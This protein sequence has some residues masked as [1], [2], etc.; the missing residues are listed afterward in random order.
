MNRFRLKT[1][2]VLACLLI[3]VFFALFWLKILPN[4]RAVYVYNI[5]KRSDFISKIGPKERVNYG[6]DRAGIIGDPVYFSLRVPRG[7]DTARMLV[8][9]RNPDDLP[10][11]EAGLLVDNVV[12]R[13]KME[14]VENRLLDELFSFWHPIK[15]NSV[16]LLQ[17]DEEYESIDEFLSD[18]PPS[19]KIAVYNYDLKTEYVIEDYEP[20]EEQ[21]IAAPL[22]G[23]WQAYVYLKDETLSL[24]LSL[25]DQNKN[26]DKDDVELYLYYDNKLIDSLSLKD[27]RS[28]EEGLK[29]KSQ[30]MNMELKLPSLPE[31]VY[32][33]ELKAGSDIVTEKIESAQSKFAFIGKL[34]LLK[35]KAPVNV[36]TNSRRLQ[37]ITTDPYSLQNIEI[38]PGDGS[39]T[40]DLAV[41]ET[42]KQFES[43]LLSGISLAKLEKDGLIISGDGVFSF[44]K[45]S[46][47]D[48]RIKK[49]DKDLDLNAVD[50]VIARYEDP[51]ED[52]DWKTAVA[53]FDL[54]QGYIEDNKY[55][56]M[57]SA[58][59][60]RADDEQD[61]MIE[62]GEIRLELK[63][64]SLWD[65]AKE[66]FNF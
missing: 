46:L 24:K 51:D 32:K 11:I 26:K 59:G 8:K 15:E 22:V 40:L 63:G 19:S 65:K 25:Y 45:Q 14:P 18:P 55:G 39:R 38:E 43:D 62:I 66:I 52:E 30:N 29:E 4:G 6:R 58:P 9:Y 2:M 23:A 17:K 64:K 3:A 50:F 34:E 57:I 5:P 61:D 37:A 35:T 27:D 48:P 16:L 42:Y 49:A 28:E 7:F 41:K 53:R 56:F 13:H 54:T 10:L 12:W 21:A 20:G 60:L 44:S 36:Y 47:I 1:R 31:G 33:I